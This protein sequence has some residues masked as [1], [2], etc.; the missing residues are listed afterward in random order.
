VAEQSQHYPGLR[1]GI[2]RGHNFGNS[3]LDTVIPL[4][5]RSFELTPQDHLE[6]LNPTPMPCGD[7]L[8][9]RIG[10][11]SQRAEKS[12]RHSDLEIPKRVFRPANSMV[13]DYDRRNGVHLVRPVYIYSAGFQKKARKSAVDRSGQSGVAGVSGGLSQ[14][15][16]CRTVAVT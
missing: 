8:Q 11:R 12:Q 2:G 7:G 15:K 9:G 6:Q 14:G 10:R 5:D 16:K 4:T 13:I 3:D 1:L